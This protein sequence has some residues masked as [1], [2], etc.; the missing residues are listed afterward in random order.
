[1]ANDF[2]QEYQDCS[3]KKNSPFK[4]WLWENSVLKTMQKNGVRSL[5]YTIYNIQKLK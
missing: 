4:K 5:T 1:M 2:W 3:V